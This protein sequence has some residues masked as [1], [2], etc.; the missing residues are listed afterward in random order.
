MKK[1]LLLIIILIFGFIQPTKSESTVPYTYVKFFDCEKWLSIDTNDCNISIYYMISS[2]KI[3]IS[4]K[5]NDLN[6]KGDYKIYLF[7]I[8]GRKIIENDIKNP[9]TFSKNIS[10]GFY[11]IKV[12]SNSNV[13]NRVINVD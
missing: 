4:V 9:V 8:F 10:P 1:I 11:Y 2:G 5:S 3:D 6:I 7:D 13:Y 12:A